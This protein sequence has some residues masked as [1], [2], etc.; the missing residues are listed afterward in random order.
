MRRRTALGGIVAALV[1]VTAGTASAAPAQ[2]FQVTQ[3]GDFVLIGNTLAQDCGSGVPAPIVGNVGACGTN[4]TDSAPDVYW[5]ADAPAAGQASA[6]TMVGVSAARTTANLTLPLGATVTHAYLYWAAR[7]PTGVA[8]LNVSLD[9]PAPFPNAFAENV[10]AID[11]IVGDPLSNIDEFYQSVADITAL[12]QQ[13][14]SGPYR[15]GGVDSVA[16]NNVPNNSLFAGWW[17]VVVYELQS[18][19]PRN[20]TLF[21]GF[22][23]VSSEDQDGIAATISGFA[24][25]LAAYN[26]KLG[27]VAYEGDDQQGGDS[28]SWNATTLSDA[29]N[30]ANNFFN[31]TRSRLGAPVSVMGDLPQLAGAARSMSGIDLDILD[32][33]SIVTPGST[34]AQLVAKTSSDGYILGGFVTAI[35]TLKPDFTSSAKSVTDLNGGTLNPGDELEYT[36]VVSNTGDDTSKETVLTDKLPAEVTYV[37]GSLEVVTGPN[38]GVK[39]D[40]T[41]DDQGEFDAATSTVVVRLGAGANASVGGS[42]NVGE[43]TTIRFRVTVNPGVGGSI[44]NQAVISASG[45]QGAPAEDTPTDG[46]GATPGAPPTVVIV[47]S[48]ADGISNDDE[49]AAGTD[50]NDADS[51][52]DGVT[53]GMEPQWDVDSDG[54]GL[55]NALD[56]DSDNDG[57]LDGTEL[58]LGCD[59][60]ATNASAGAC[61]PDADMGA[62]TTDPL[63]A[64][65]DN[66]GVGDGSE[67]GNLNGQIDPGEGNPL[68][69]SDDN[70]IADTDGDGLSDIVEGTLGSDPNDADSDDDGVIDGQEPNPSI[71]TDGDGVPNVL[72]ADSDNDG[73]FD[74]TELGLDCSNAATNVSAGTCKPDADMGAT[75]TSPIDADTDDGGVSDGSE[76]ANLNGQ[77]DPGEGDPN[78]PADDSTI[79]DSDNDG[80]SDIVEGTL[81]TDPNDADSDDDG[82]PDGE[83]PNP[84]E[85]SDGDGLIN[86]LD[87]D[88][89]NDGLLDGTE[90]GYDCKAPGTNEAYCVPDADMGATKTSPIDADTDDGGVNDGS[91]DSNL[92]GQI[93]P[94]EKDPN[95]PSD[96]STVL[97]SDGDGLS[98]DLEEHLGSDPNDADTDD[99]GVL[100]GAEPNPSFDTDGD[101][102]PNITDADSDNDGLF[103][104]TELGLGCDNPATDKTEG[105]CVPDAD[106]G[107]TKTSPIDADTDDGGVS[108]G[109]EDANLN[110]VIDPGEGNPNDPSDDSTIV[111]TDGDGLSDDLEGFL[112]SDPNDADTDD[113]GVID[114]KEPNPSDDSDGDGIKNVVDPDSDNDGL[115]DGLELGFDCSNPATDPAANLCKADADSG[116]TTTSP[117]DA[118]TDNGGIPDGV[119]D[120]NGNGAVDS[121]ET[122]PNDPSDDVVEECDV[123]ADCGGPTSGMVCDESNACVEGCRGSGGN[124]CPS[125]LECTSMDGSI[126]QCVDPTGAGG[127]GT[128]GGGTGGGDTADGV[129]LGGGCAG[130]AVATDDDASRGLLAALGVALLAF[131]RR[132]R[133]A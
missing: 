64:D 63:D 30:P 77:I 37:P 40:A 133:R 123:D 129:K 131:G 1:C 21:D 110:G 15:L 88:S 2:R 117:I 61:R 56:P 68:D 31:G 19:P 69:P 118:D 125:E 53:D 107:A 116:A 38:M 65:T 108:D 104:G 121:G 22:D 67:D 4:T 124:A 58:G 14:G 55:I 12:V 122:D 99:D 72:D 5:Q 3:R 47:D 45:T 71:D 80:L 74:G 32:I 60:P 103:D 85:D 66:G 127:G 109:S 18:E 11:S 49:N 57:L 91:E 83:E 111:D 16:L 115:P 81:G 130:C 23:E 89:D 70:T 10:A 43:T 95:D 26:A 90:L 78:N 52:D 44:I 54:D 6:S 93:D 100:D 29:A 132:R 126:G 62:T 112:G 59:D 101:G 84:A 76:D 9:R 13:Y 42:L 33:T 119:E 51:D 17:M 28:L 20:I 92:N 35:S 41:A 86:A 97:D 50:P 7:S 105:R 25:P 27:V 48:D 102:A 114:G 36:I 87:P 46:N 39:T 98:N 113:D 106:M 75:T 79:V 96:D 8:D 34:S 82:V 120:A 94:G 128:G 24:V 73:L